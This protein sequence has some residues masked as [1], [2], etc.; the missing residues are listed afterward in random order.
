MKRTLTIILSAGLIGLGS[1]AILWPRQ[2][3]TVTIINHGNQPIASVRVEHEREIE[4]LE[5]IG[6][7]ESKAVQF[8]A[9]GETSYKLVV[10]FVDGSEVS[11]GGG[12]A[13]SGYKVQRLSWNREST[14]T[15]DYHPID[16]FK[17]S[18]RE[19]APLADTLVDASR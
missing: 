10:R 11:G 7:G 3:I 5:H 15:S 17:R 19:N 13:E 12:Y 18:G 14:P 16:I 2:P 6:Q 4:L 1:L 8:E 9:R